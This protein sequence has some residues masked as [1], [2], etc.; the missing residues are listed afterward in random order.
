M[1][2]VA[3][4]FQQRLDFGSEELIR[5]RQCNISRPGW[6]CNQQQAQQHD[7]E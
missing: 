1:T 5:I 3:A 2:L 7:G 4:L 6:R